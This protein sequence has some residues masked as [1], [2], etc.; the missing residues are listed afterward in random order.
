ML[1]KTLDLKTT[2]YTTSSYIT[3]I[4]PIQIELGTEVAD[5][6]SE[7]LFFREDNQTINKAWRL[8]ETHFVVIAT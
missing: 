8:H 7:K 5:N 2:T 3:G 1:R 6:F 4:V